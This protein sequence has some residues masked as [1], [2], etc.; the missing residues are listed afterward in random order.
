MTVVTMRP[1]TP[2]QKR[3]MLDATQV[4]EF[5]PKAGASTELAPLPNQMDVG[6]FTK[7]GW[8]R[9]DDLSD[10]A[11][12]RAGITLAAVERATPWWWGDWWLAR[13]TRVLPP[14]WLGPDQKTLDNYRVVAKSFYFPDRRGNVPFA[15]YDALTSATANERKALLTWA[16]KEAPTIAEF[17]AERRRRNDAKLTPKLAVV[18]QTE[19]EEQ[20]TAEAASSLEELT[21]KVAVQLADLEPETTTVSRAVTV[22]VPVDL[23]AWVEQAADRM[24]TDVGDW[25]VKLLEQERRMTP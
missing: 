24:N 17:R 14:G 7:I 4:A 23:L 25:I 21:A 1:R 10:E 8:Q 2:A 3:E 18:E 16:E 9:P 5:T 20:S 6:I 12:A 19:A 15:I 13:E 22:Y 11:W